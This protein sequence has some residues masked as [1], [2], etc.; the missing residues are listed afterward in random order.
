M[1]CYEKVH[2]NILTVHMIVYPLS[3]S[4]RHLIGVQIIIILQREK[5][6]Q[7]SSY[8]TYVHKHIFRLHV[9]KENLSLCV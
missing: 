9:F 8:C 2:S 6:G 4:S 5:I 3:Y 1:I 7:V